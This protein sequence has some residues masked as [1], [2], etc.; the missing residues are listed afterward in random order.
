MPP[1][2]SGNGSGP[3]RGDRALARLRAPPPPALEP[4]PKATGGWAGWIRRRIDLAV[5]GTIE[6]LTEAICQSVGD[7]RHSAAPRFAE[8]E[9]RCG[10]LE[11][12]L[13]ELEAAQARDLR[14]VSDRGRP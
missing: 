8:A 12:R 5:A 14:V 3:C 13:A 11:A 7:E 10:E 2:K 4:L 6:A 9:R 1:V